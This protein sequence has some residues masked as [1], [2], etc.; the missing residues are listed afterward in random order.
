MEDF[1]P[2]VCRLGMFLNN[3]G[4]LRSFRLWGFVPDTCLVFDIGCVK[5]SDISCYVWRVEKVC[6]TVIGTVWLLGYL[7]F[8]P[9]LTSATDVENSNVRLRRKAIV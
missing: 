3:D 5:T 1:V 8:E 4:G 2:C 7:C 9:F 6:L